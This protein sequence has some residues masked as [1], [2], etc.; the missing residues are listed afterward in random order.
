MQNDKRNRESLIL[1]LYQEVAGKKVN[2]IVPK[3]TSYYNRFKQEEAM[4]YPTCRKTSCFS[5][6]ECQ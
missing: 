6:G 4:Y 3:D 5:C 1:S 2:E